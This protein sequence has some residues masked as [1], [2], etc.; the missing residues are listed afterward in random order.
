MANF[1]IQ[2]CPMSDAVIKVIGVGGGA[3]EMPWPIWWNRGYPG[4]NSLP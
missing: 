3:E 2:E 1:E 4:S